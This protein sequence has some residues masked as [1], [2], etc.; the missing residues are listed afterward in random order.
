M[1][2]IPNIKIITELGQLFYKSAEDL[3]LNFTRVVEDMAEIDNRF[4]DFSYEFELP[5]TK[6]NS[7]IFGSPE[8]IGSKRYFI[9]NKNISCQ[10]YD[11]NQLLLDGLI[12]LEGLTK[13][14]YRCKFFSKFKELVDALNSENDL[15]EKKTLRDLQFP[16]VDWDYEDSIINHINADYKNSDE[17]FYQY[18]L[19]FYSTFYCQS[20][21]FT[22]YTDYQS[23][24][25][26]SDW[27]RQNFYYLLNSIGSE[28]N[29]IY[30]HQVPPAIYLVS[31][32]DQ[33]LED[34]GWTLGG[35]FFNDDNL[36]KI[37]LLYSGEDDPYDLAISGVT[38]A[39]GSYPLKLQMAKFLPDMSQSEFLKGIM[40]MFN[41]YFRIDVNNKIIEF[42]NYDTYFRYI[43]D[44]DAYDITSK[45]D[46]SAPH[47]FKYFENNNP[48]VMFTKAENRLLFGDNR[49]MSGATDNATSTIWINS[50]NKAYNQVFNRIG[51]VE[52][53]NQRQN[54]FGSIV[55]RIEIPF[56]EPNIKRQFI[57]NDYDING[58]DQ[59][60]EV[61]NIYL[62]I[63]S[64]QTIADNDGMKFNK[65]DN[66]T[67]LMN[68]EST[69][70][71]RGSGALMYYYGKSTTDEEN[72]SGKGTLANYM[73]Y[74]MYSDTGST[75][76]RISIPV[77]S[78]FQLLDS[79]TEIRN[80]LT[81]VTISNVDDRRTAVA[82]YL[83][84]LQQ[85]MISSTGY[86]TD[87]LT[88]YSLVFDDAGYF[89]ETLWTRFHQYK[90]TRY[91]ESEVFEGEMI[92]N[93]YDWYQM[94]IN[95]PLKYRGELYSLL[96]V[97]SYNPITQRAQ[98]KMIKKL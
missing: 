42:E 3:N 7:K 38:E 62:P 41:L 93:A 83:Q 49:I 46:L 69:I 55:E 78:P 22:G 19:S 66:E 51:Y 18:P 1:S 98:I 17:T 47:G 10:V 97:D 65:A 74:N 72:K 33:I 84:A 54:V 89:H 37:V 11:N 27:P 75:L 92:M 96:S 31:I 12:N 91:Q 4:G 77:V 34:A 15:G 76:T 88:D 63:L 61:H 64:V 90:W 45:V 67:Y 95:K 13:D 32:I 56:A 5:I 48:S 24:S 6:E 52:Q 85:L 82:S 35:Q 30:F 43:D 59:S 58:V 87:Q 70:K 16:L 20:S 21:Y 26:R 73:Y 2:Y 40:N 53:S 86:T 28:D 79:N 68:N 23:N 14:T 94:Q 8:T 57:W 71:F 25:F 80:W 81:G 50:T 9:I 29:R 60:G 39:S 36:K 44:I